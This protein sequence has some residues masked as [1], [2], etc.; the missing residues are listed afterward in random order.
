MKKCITLCLTLVLALALAAT[1]SASGKADLSVIGGADG[2]TGIFVTSAPTAAEDRET[3]AGNGVVEMQINGEYIDFTGAEP[4]IVGGRTMVPM[5]GVLDAL[6]AQVDYDHPSKTVTA[7]L[8]GV[9]LRHTIGTEEIT[10]SGGQVLTMD[11]ASYV[12]NGSV[13]V[14]V[15]F[16]SQALG[17]EVYWD[18]G[19]RTAV[20]IDKQKLISQIDS[21]F[22][23]LNGFQEKQA[24]GRG[25]NLAMTMDLD[26]T[27][28]VLD[29]I[30][31]DKEYPFSMEMTGLYG[32]SAINAQGS[33]DLSILTALMEAMDEEVPQE[34]AGLLKDFDFQMICSSAGLWMQMP[35]V[36]DMLRASGEAVPQGEVWFQLDGSG[37]GDMMD[38][39]GIALAAQREAVTMGGMLYAMAEYSDLEVPVNIYDDVTQAAG[40][41]TALVGD[42]AFARDGG[43]YVWTLDQAAMDTLAE[44]LGASSAA[45]PGTMEMTLHADGSS[46]FSLDLTVDEAP[47]ALT[48]TM[49]GT[50]TATDSAFQGRVQV[51][52]VC[53]VTFQAAA[54]VQASQTAPFPAPPADAVIVD[55]GAAPLVMSP[56][57]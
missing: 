39:Y 33:M 36:M 42:D 13:M 3:S 26:G 34:M 30:G 31:G 27:A 47:L 28:K 24:A 15:R 43:D 41:L 20:V 44:A 17:L 23:I 35:A 18:R 46:A 16:F 25:E 7:A 21:G 53:D 37:A 50:S 6:G 52:N 54:A 40:L 4:E 48:M 5:R 8:G 12:K 32:P 51:K 10:V 29:S 49:S 1:A 14:P 22:A 9:S 2:P 11:G 45:F 56:A 19:Q 57:A 38:L 55:M